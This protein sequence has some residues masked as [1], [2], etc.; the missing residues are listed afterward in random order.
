MDSLNLSAGKA[1][2]KAA[3]EKSYNSLNTAYTDQ[4]KLTLNPADLTV[5]ESLPTYSSPLSLTSKPPISDQDAAAGRPLRLAARKKVVDALARVLNE[6]KRIKA[7]ELVSS[8]TYKIT[9]E[10]ADAKIII[11]GDFNDD[12]T[13]KSIKNHLVNDTFYNP[14]ERL[15]SRGKGTL[16]H[17]STWH[18]FDQ[19]IFSKNFFDIETNQ[20]SFKYAEVYDK[21]FLKEIEKSKQDINGINLILSKILKIYIKSVWFIPPFCMEK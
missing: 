13:S 5:D 19:I 16:N 12:P 18:L 4:T 8:I 11:M 7:A 14:M 9:D 21:Q 10:T 3:G 6:E 1:A 15:I 17:N 20:H 2:G